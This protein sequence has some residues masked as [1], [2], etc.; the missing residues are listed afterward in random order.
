MT[1]QFDITRLKC[2]MDARAIAP[3]VGMLAEETIA[4]ELIPADLVLKDQ[5]CRHDAHPDSKSLTPFQAAEVLGEALEKYLPVEYKGKYDP[6]FAPTRTVIDLWKLR[7]LIDLLGLP[8][9]LYV[10]T[11]AAYVGKPKG[12]APRLSQLMHR[13]VIAHVAREWAGRS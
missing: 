1:T 10:A 8:Y 9:E 11:A 2:L 7:Q 12:R 3:A 5:E 13:D 6:K 4:R